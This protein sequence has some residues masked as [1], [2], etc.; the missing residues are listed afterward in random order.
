M[1]MGEGFRPLVGLAS[2]AWKIW[3]RFWF[4][5]ECDA[6]MRLLRIA[7]AGLLLCF[8][9]NVL[10][11]F[12]LLYTEDGL[13]RAGLIEDVFPMKGRFS[14]F[15][16]FTSDRSIY[17][18]YG[19][20][21]VSFLSMVLGFLPRLAAIMAFVLHISFIHRNVTAVFGIDLIATFFLLYL[22]LAN[23]PK[24]GVKQSEFS[25][26]LQSI[27]LRL[28]QIQLCIV[29]AY[30]G[31][32]KVKGASWWRGDALWY[33]L[34]NPQL[35]RFD[36]TWTSSWPVLLAFMTYSTLLWEIYFPVLIWFP[37]LRR[38]MLVGGVM[39]HGGIAFLISLPFFSLIMLSSYAG[40]LTEQEALAIED[41]GARILRRLIPRKASKRRP[42]LAGA[43]LSKN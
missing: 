1:T 7:V 35:A 10:P 43:A 24:R 5:A 40:F 14:V 8:Y 42:A 3:C 27:A 11:D 15:D 26:T 21:M 6:R 19:L 4:E 36:F 37:K 32:E 41:R 2:N 17:I 39:L 34:S 31:W 33:V 30:S 29:Y 38:A 20:L 16:F 12:R 23:T 22:C 18:A 25:R 13:L 28:V 9:L